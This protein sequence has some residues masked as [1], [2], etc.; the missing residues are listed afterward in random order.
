MEP[1]LYEKRGYLRED[2]RLFHL[3]DTAMVPVSWHYHTFH[4]IIFFLSG[5]AAYD[6][7]GQRYALAPGD[8]LLVG[9]GSIHRPEI[10]GDVP[11]ERVI[12]YLDPAFLRAQSTAACDLEACFSMARREFRFALRPVAREARLPEILSALEQAVEGGGFGAALLCRALLVQLLI[13]VSRGLLDHGL[14]YV[15]DAA[16]DEKTVAILRYLNAHLTER[17]AIDDLAARFYLS[18]FYMMRRFRAETGHTIHGYLVGKRL[19]L[20]RALMDGGMTA[21]DACFQSGF[22]D[23]STFSRAYK[24]QFGRTPRQGAGGGRGPTEA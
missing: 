17:I 5:H 4:K 13:E 24:R 3:R 18:K 1:E 11:Y 23:Y 9:Q 7:E 19:M 6:I 22:Q 10:G 14:A 16:F 12:L 21:T 2:Y 20:A 15:T 8:I